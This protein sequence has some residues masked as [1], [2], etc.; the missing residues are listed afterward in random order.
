VACIDG[1]VA[2]DVGTEHACAAGVV[3]LLVGV[4]GEADRLSAD[5]RHVVT[6]WER[7]RTR[8]APQMPATLEGLVSTFRAKRRRYRAADD[9]RW[10]E[11]M[12]AAFQAVFTVADQQQAKRVALA[13]ATIVGEAKFARAKLWPMI[14]AR[15]SGQFR[16][17]AGEPALS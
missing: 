15:F 11:A 3:A 7:R 2:L 12:G 5:G 14:D 9:L 17:N 16:I 6:N 8:A 1:L 4:K 13:A 10:R